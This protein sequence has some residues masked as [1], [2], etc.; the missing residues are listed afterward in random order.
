[1]ENMNTEIHVVINRNNSVIGAYTDIEV[2]R[3]VSLVCG[4]K[5]E[6]VKINH[7]YP[8]FLENIGMCYGEETKKKIE[9]LTVTDLEVVKLCVF[10]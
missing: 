4:L 1:M 7:I 3:K 5:I 9:E 6:T 10:K 2:A 8:G